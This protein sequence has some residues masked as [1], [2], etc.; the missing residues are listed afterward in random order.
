MGKWKSLTCIFSRD[1][2]KSM[3]GAAT[4]RWLKDFGRGPSRILLRWLKFKS[5]LHAD[6]SRSHSELESSESERLSSD[7]SHSLIVSEMKSALDQFSRGFGR[8]ASDSGE[9]TSRG[10][11]KGS[12]FLNVFR[13]G[14]K[15]AKEDICDDVVLASLVFDLE[16]VFREAKDPAFDP[17]SRGQISSK[18]ITKSCIV[19]TQEK[20][21]SEQNHSEMLDGADHCVKLDF[22]R[23]IVALFAGEGFRE[24]AH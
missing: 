12:R 7:S 17:G 9:F 21:F 20:L 13:A 22:I 4:S 15:Q 1:I 23:S 24:E 2:G 10:L 16:G 8:G 6:C 14:E 11:V 3:K 5:I 19:G 18:E